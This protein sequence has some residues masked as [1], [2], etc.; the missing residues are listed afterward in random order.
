MYRYSTNSSSWNLD[1]YIQPGKKNEGRGNMKC[2]FVDEATGLGGNNIP[3]EMMKKFN[4]IRK[5]KDGPFPNPL[6]VHWEYGKYGEKLG[7]GYW[8]HKEMNA[9]VPEVIELF[10]FLWCGLNSEQS[11]HPNHQMLMNIDWSGN[12]AAMAADAMCI[13]NMRVGY[14]GTHS[15]VGEDGK[16]RVEDLPI[17]KPCVLKDGD[18]CLENVPEEWKDKVRQ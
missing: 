15:V 10:E 16:K 3:A 9:L 5:N 18:L 2:V 14:G 7:M 6:L 13:N 17:L 4:S 1:G 12:H 8:T 11:A